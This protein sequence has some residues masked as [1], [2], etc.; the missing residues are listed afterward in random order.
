[1]I[2][3]LHGFGGSFQLYQYY[4]ARQFSDHIIICPAYGI[5]MAEVPQLY[6]EECLAEAQGKIGHRLR[7]P[8]LMGLSAG[9]FGGFREYARNSSAYSGFICL[10]AYPPE[11]MLP[12]EDKNA[13]MRIL[14]G[15]QEYWVKDRTL[16]KSEWKLLKGNY[17][18][19]TIPGADHF[20]LLTHER[21]SRRFLRL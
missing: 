19:A 16:E 15:A 14:A 6:L 17:H 2:L 18:H 13:K 3:F 8:I 9:G 1:M 12:I 10:A 21:E 11:D 5:S 20:F 4:L 7:R